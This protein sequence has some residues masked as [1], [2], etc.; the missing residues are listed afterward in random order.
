MST[1]LTSKG[2]SR[3]HF[4]SSDIDTMSPDDDAYFERLKEMKDKYRDE[5]AIVYRELHRVNGV[6][7][8]FPTLT[9]H[10]SKNLPNFLIN[11]KKIIFLLEQQ[12]H[13]MPGMIPRRKRTL[14]YLDI[15]ETH[16]QRKVLPILKRLRTTYSI[17]LEPLIVNYLK[18][19]STLRR[20]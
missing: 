3:S 4:T 10:G 7:A 16:I 19:S 12:C 5:V 1:C 14:T 20:L 11:L 8:Q 17:I 2:T 15:I 18:H 9:R 6:I 13:E